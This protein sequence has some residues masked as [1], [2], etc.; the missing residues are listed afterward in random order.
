MIFH[1]HFNL[2]FPHDEWC[3]TSFHLPVGH[4]YI[5]SGKIPTQML[6]SFLNRVIHFC[7]CCCWVVPVSYQIYNLQIQSALRIHWFC[8][9]RSNGPSKF[10]ESGWRWRTHTSR[11]PT[12][13]HHFYMRD[14]STLG[15]WYLQ[16]VVQQRMRYNCIFSHFIVFTVPLLC[17][18]VLLW[19]RPTCLF[20]L[21]LLA[22][23][24]TNSKNLCQ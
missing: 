2:H 3:L 18:N 11:G 15:F 5:F 24:M 17:R 9:H 16:Q 8:M 19:C 13:L 20:L 7:C 6:C 22:L 23:L 10:D 14:L 21:L 1:C 4:L 12:V